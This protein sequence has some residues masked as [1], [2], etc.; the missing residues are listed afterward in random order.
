MRWGETPAGEG[1]P[2]VCLC[3]EDV[4]I[5]GEGISQP[6]RARIWNFGARE[7]FETLPHED[8]CGKKTRKCWKC[9]GNLKTSLR[10]LEKFS[11]IFC[12][13][14]LDVGTAFKTFVLTS[15]SL[16][17]TENVPVAMWT[18]ST[19]RSRRWSARSSV[20]PRFRCRK[21]FR[22]INSIIRRN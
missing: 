19:R 4:Q 3:A 11:Y 12:L 10:Q 21:L 14:L 9:L 15:R 22:W 6:F 8:F 2:C 18:R 20:K 16:C 13:S 1:A 5:S 17:S 7:E